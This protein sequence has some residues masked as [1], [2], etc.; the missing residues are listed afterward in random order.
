MLE[1]HTFNDHDQTV[2]AL[3]HAVTSDILNTLKQTNSFSIAVAGGNTPK[4]F[5]HKLSSAALPWEK[6]SV[7]LTDERWVDSDHPDSNEAMLKGCL[8]QN[9]AATA[10]FVALKNPE[11]S[12]H[13]GKE[14]CERTLIES[15]SPL[16]LVML[17]MG[18]DGHFASIFPGME[19][20]EYLLDMENRKLC[21]GAEPAGKPPR[22]SLTLSYISTADQIY[23]LI[24]GEKKKQIIDD[25]LNNDPAACALPIATLFK[26]C[27]VN[28]YWNP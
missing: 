5:F 8:F 22:M 19:N 21:D 4:P 1:L 11:P 15:I 7:T 28:V 14:I 12:P 27:K 2:D 9:Q 16:N 18:E 3:Y 24:T 6:V 25:I 17:G 26:T 23:L 20:T 13:E 10:K